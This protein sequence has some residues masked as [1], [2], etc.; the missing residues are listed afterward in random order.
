[1]K[2]NEIL[3]ISYTQPRLSREKMERYIEY[4]IT[5]GREPT[6]DDLAVIY[7]YFMPAGLSKLRKNF[8][9]FEWFSAGADRFYVCRCLIWV[10]ADGSHIMASKWHSVHI[11]ID[12]RE[13]GYYCTVKVVKVHDKDWSSY[14]DVDQIMP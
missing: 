1:M 2:L 3:A 5:K 13:P 10:Y 11:L 12:V 6:V 14:P 7:R 4:I 8:T 9:S